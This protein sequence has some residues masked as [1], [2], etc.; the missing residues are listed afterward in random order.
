[1]S[2]ST[3]L[4]KF[5]SYGTQALAYDRVRQCLRQCALSAEVSDAI[6]TPIWRIGISLR[7]HAVL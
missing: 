4:K 7:H 6:S 1:M 3:H 5:V 2:S